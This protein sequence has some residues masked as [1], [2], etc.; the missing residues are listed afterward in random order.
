MVLHY[1]NM[2]KSYDTRID[3][4]N[5]KNSEQLHKLMESHRIDLKEF[6]DK[7]SAQNK[8]IGDLQAEIAAVESVNAKLEVENI[9]K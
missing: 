5:K 1:E 3:D 7:S 4:I 9:H 2:V 6:S 8:T